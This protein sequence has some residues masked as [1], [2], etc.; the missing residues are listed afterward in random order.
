MEPRLT[1]LCRSVGKLNLVDLA[2][3]ERQRK[4]GAGGERLREA[5]RINQALS[6]LGN[7]ISALAE[8]SP[9]VPYRYVPTANEGSC[10]LRARAMFKRVELNAPRPAAS[11]K[12]V[13]ATEVA[14]HRPHTAR[15]LHDDQ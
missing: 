14:R 2:G 10:S 11:V 5:A 12:R 9:H 7:V 3:S 15:A 13:G 1:C 6:S 4:T 8:N